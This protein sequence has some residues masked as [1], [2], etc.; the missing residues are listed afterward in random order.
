[1]AMSKLGFGSPRS[2]V[3]S[4]SPMRLLTI[5]YVG[6]LALVAAMAILGSGVVHRIIDRER[7][8]GVVINMAGRQRM[9]SQALAKQGLALINAQT[10]EQRRHYL[11]EMK[12]TV[13]LFDQTQDALQS[14]NSTELEALFA[15]AAPMQQALADG[16]QK[17]IA[18]YSVT[19]PGSGSP[20]MPEIVQILANEGPFLSAMEAIMARYQ[21]EFESRIAWLNKSEEIVLAVILVTLFLE[22]MFIFRPTTRIIRDSFNRLEKQESDLREMNRKLDGALQDSEKAARAKSEF[23]AVMSHEIRTPMNAVIGM[24]SILA[25]T[26]LTEMQRECVNTIS[27]SGELLMTVIND[28]LDFSKIESG[29]MELES[30]SF[31]VRDCVEEALALFSPQIRGKGLEA[32]SLVAPDVPFHLVGDAMRLRQILFNLIGNAIKFTSKGEIAVNVERKAQ[33]E[34]GCQLEFSVKD[35]GI[36]ISKEGI[37]KIFNAFQQ[38]DT[39]TTRRYGG[40]G[41]GLV[42]CKGL[43]EHMGGTIWVESEPGSGST[44]FFSVT[45]KASEEPVLNPQ[46]G[47]SDALV[48]RSALIVDDNASNR[49]ILE[50]QLRTWGMNPTCVSSGATGLSKA[51]ERHFDVGLI[52]YQMP[53]MDGVMTAREIRKQSE[54]PLILLS[55]SGE[56]IGGEDAKL[57]Q[58]Q[59]SKPIRYSFLFA[60]LLQIIGTESAR[61][62]Q[63]LE[64]KFDSD[65]A[66]RHPLRIL[67][68][69]D[70]PVNQQ[71]G[72]LMLS[73]LGYTTDLVADGL[74]AV[75]AVG[76]AEYDLILM[77]IQM[78]NMNGVEAG[79]MIRETLGA[80]CPSIFALT[81]EAL[82]GD[83]EKFLGLGF[84]GYLSKPIE[85]R[86]LQNTLETVNAGTHLT[87]V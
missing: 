63:I 46:L 26:K 57:F 38:V 16:A 78:P 20:Q 15:R 34:T 2:R 36:G 24:T 69:E 81:A 76:K 33:D 85:I 35:T 82:E 6:A 56:T 22:G 55:S 19:N 61:S 79:R 30:R 7:G 74:Q 3:R 75:G 40:T 27:S 67:L 84:D 8:S 29:R 31:D 5:Y 37:D 39:S 73:R 28:I 44:F 72:K 42:I 51:A 50:I 12:T 10:P 45:L 54:T 13:A 66:T 47:K 59:I 77:D 25:E 41:L 64:K 9:R 43:A 68:A 53:E 23:L 14:G 87:N 62:R 17:L 32:V 11:E 49:R 71:V 21:F 65:M 86:T 83:K 4:A 60:A 70:N 58:A 18:H 48:S 52:D 80:K 1:M